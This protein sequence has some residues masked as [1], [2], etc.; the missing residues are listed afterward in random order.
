MAVPEDILKEKIKTQGP[1]SFEE[2]MK[3]ALYH[4]EHGYYM[5]EVERIGPAGDYYTS[6]HLH[7]LFGYMI[8][9]QIIELISMI[10]RPDL[11]V[12]EIGA[13]RGYMAEGILQ[14]LYDH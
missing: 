3:E 11:K 7:P 4:P 9:I 12:V 10:A 14:C 6:P 13:G 1:I 8:G 5:S 2:F